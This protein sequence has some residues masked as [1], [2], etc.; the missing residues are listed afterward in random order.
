MQIAVVAWYNLKFSS[1]SEQPITDDDTDRISLCLRVLAERAPFMYEIFNEK[2]RESLS[3]ML[4][5]KADEEKM[6]QKVGSL[7]HTIT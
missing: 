3:V 5:A 4:A 2:C 7:Y 1:I 6:A